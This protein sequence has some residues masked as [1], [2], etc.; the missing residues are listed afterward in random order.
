MDSDDFGSASES[1]NSSSISTGVN[2][3]D[4]VF[5]SDV[6]DFHE[7]NKEFSKTLRIPKYNKVL[8]R[9]LYDI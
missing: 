6:R 5:I 9:F 4:D 1:V 3:K 8:R 7:R 2:S